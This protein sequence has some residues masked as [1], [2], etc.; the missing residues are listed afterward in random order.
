M[1][2]DTLNDL[3]PVEVAEVLREFY[4]EA[5]PALERFRDAEADTLLIAVSELVISLLE[6]T[7]TSTLTPGSL[8]GAGVAARIQYRLDQAIDALVKLRSRDALRGQLLMQSLVGTSCVV[9]R[10]FQHLL[11]RV[12]RGTQAALPS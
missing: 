3:P 7:G 11:D 12:R 10:R 4:A 9:I 1:M 2:T 8:D 6:A 5:L